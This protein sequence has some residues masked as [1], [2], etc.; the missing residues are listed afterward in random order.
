MGMLRRFFFRMLPK[1]FVMALN[2]YEKVS[3]LRSGQPAITGIAAYLLVVLI[4]RGAQADEA[5]FPDAVVDVL[6]RGNSQT[7][8]LAHLRIAANKEE[9][10]CEIRE[11]TSQL[12]CQFN[13]A[14]WN[15]II[16]SKESPNCVSFRAS[17]LL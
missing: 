17:R 14:L 8:V 13:G 4:V 7:F 11:Q 12:L 10:N 16:A 6:M 15:A 2:G 9:M 1:G 3:R 5:K